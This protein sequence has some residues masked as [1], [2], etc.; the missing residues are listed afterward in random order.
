[1]NLQTPDRGTWLNQGF[2]EQNGGCGYV[3]KPKV[4]LKPK[5]DPQNVSTFEL[6]GSCKIAVTVFSARH[7][8]GNGTMSTW[9]SSPCFVRPPSRSVPT[10]LSRCVLV[11]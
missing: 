7:L 2:F 6:G 9:V 11:R 4:M 3:L 1:M 10:W 8:V 5:F